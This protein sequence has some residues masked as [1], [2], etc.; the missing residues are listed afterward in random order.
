MARDPKQVRHPSTNRV[1]TTEVEESVGRCQHL[2]TNAKVVLV[3]KRVE[4]TVFRFLCLCTCAGG[5]DSLV[6]IQSMPC[7]AFWQLSNTE[8][9][10]NVSPTFWFSIL[11]NFPPPATFSVFGCYACTVRPHPPASGRLVAPGPATSRGDGNDT[12]V[13]CR[14][15]LLRGLRRRG[16]CTHHVSVNHVCVSL[17]HVRKQAPTL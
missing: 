11:L 5:H 17:S 15:L 1:H 14:Q 6:N 8:R 10:G 13:S 3:L 9:E 16:T 4:P 2:H 7:T 12:C